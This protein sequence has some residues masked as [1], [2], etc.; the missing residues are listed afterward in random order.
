MQRILLDKDWHYFSGPY[1]AFTPNLPKIEPERWIPVELPHDAINGLPR[2]PKNPSGM[3]EA[4]T[5]AS[6]LYYKKEFDC[7]NEWGGKR[8]L[9]EFEGIYMNAHI[10]VNGNQVAFHPYGYT[11]FQVDLTPYLHIGGR[12]ILLIT[13]NNL[14]KP[15]SRW[16]AGA[17]IYRHVWLHVGEA[18]SVRPWNL[19]ITTPAVSK[20]NAEVAVRATVT[21]NSGAA[22]KAYLRASIKQKDGTVCATAQSSCAELACGESELSLKA[23]VKQPALWSTETPNLY[24]LAYELILTEGDKETVCD[25][26][27]ETFGIRSI[28]FDSVNGFRLNGVTMTMKGGCVHHDNG[29]LGSAAFDE[30]DARRVRLLKEAGYDAIRCSHN[31]PSPAFLRACDE[32]GMLVI[33]E[34]FD[35]WQVGKNAFD[36]HLYFRDWWQRDIRSMVDRDFNH[37]SIVMWSIGNEVGERDGSSN[38]AAVCRALADYTRSLDTTRAITAASNDVPSA[39]ATSDWEANL[40]GNV[41]NEDDD[42]FGYKT[43][44]FFAALDV[45][46][47]NYL[48]KRYEFD[49]EKYPN[50]V[51]FG[52]E[53]FPITAY[54]NWIEA[55][56]N[57]NC[58][59]D[60]VWTSFD[61]LG[62]S[63]IGKVELDKQ[64]GWGGAYPWFYANCGDLDIC[65]V[66]R[67]QS[68]YRDILWGLRT[69]PYIG[70]LNPKFEGHEIIYK[71]WGWEPVE[72][73]YTFPGCEGMKTKVDVYSA[74]DEVELFVNGVSVGRKPAGAAVEN[75]ARFEIVYQPGELKAVAY[76]NGSAVEEE[77]L[78]TAGKPAALRLAPEKEYSI[79]GCRHLCYVHIEVV[80]ADGKL[81]P[82]AE[83][84]IHFAVE[85]TGKL[86]AVANGNP[87]NEESFTAKERL[88]H[89]GR[90]MVI[91]ERIGDGAVT[92]K[93][94]SDGLKAECTSL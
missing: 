29:P 64:D 38:G 55:E 22:V 45:S 34:A 94:E 21:N 33:D 6:M 66:K 2:D 35:G 70:V 89:Q 92:L 17:G 78:H 91:L 36:Y 5:E 50:R 69:K 46:G 42:R 4:Y 86:L 79:E 23:V 37:P 87:I 54:E 20:E 48:T 67:P 74:Y 61:Y 76:K 18:V 88:A 7:P 8:I 40:A 9:A 63:G 80:D 90:A 31:P 60:F 62:E 59:G 71:K 24:E 72:E 77:V 25:D 28:S 93:A 14:G 65:G 13:A 68:Y 73:S 19:K 16:Y 11:S 52:S 3:A 39:A 12:N 10:V 83:N 84:L 41:V 1:M 81:V 56:K 15:N 57:P 82:Y 26:G 51:I 43:E 47:Y 32:Q 53:T 75:I 49:R 27:T 58:V 44:E 85:G 30:A